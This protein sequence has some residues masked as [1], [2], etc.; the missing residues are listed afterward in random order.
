MT[1]AIHGVLHVLK[2]ERNARIHLMSAVVVLLAGLAMRL[3]LDQLT[4]VFFAIVL[5]FLAE[6]FN[7]AVERTLDLIDLEEN[8][9]IKIIK[10]MSA[11]AVLV[12]AAAAVMIGIFV[13]GPYLARWA[14]GT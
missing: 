7:T 10:D 13:F 8:R 11:G 12:T 9:H 3:P 14:W 6:I 5:V 4:D 2:H 1:H